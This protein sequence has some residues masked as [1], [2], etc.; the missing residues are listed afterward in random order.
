MG[1]APICESCQERFA[2]DGYSHCNNCL[3]YVEEEGERDCPACGSALGMDGS[4]LCDLG[5][6]GDA[7][8][9]RRDVR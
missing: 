9:I 3:M 6:A 2:A 5:P 1:L 4:C 8:W 7:Y